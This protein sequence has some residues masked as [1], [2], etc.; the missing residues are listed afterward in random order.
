VSGG[1]RTARV[2]ARAKL[3]LALRVIARED[4]GFHQIETLFCALELGDELDVNLTDREVTLHLAA[5][6]ESPG[7]V[8]DLGPPHANLAVRAARSFFAHSGLSGGCHINLTKRIPA[9]GGLG[10]GSSDAAATLHALDRLHGAPLGR[11]R[12]LALAGELGSDVPFFVAGAAY[13]L[14]W[15]RGD[16]IAALPPL[17]SAPVLLAIPPGRIA[18]ADAYAD[19]AAARNGMRAPPAVLPIPRTWSEVGSIAANE[20]EQTVF[21]RHARLRELRELM[22]SLGAAPAR[23]TGTGSTIFGVFEDVGSAEY[24]RGVI[25]REHEDVM[26]LLTRTL[27]AV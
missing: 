2:I 17:P 13:A 7:D 4:S 1:D 25:S 23:M 5:P 12:L 6:P 9:G 21:A 20:F 22:Q 16:R 19:L 15:G 26:L 18:T 10:G 14:A 27:E 11:A 24:A 3:N 8:P